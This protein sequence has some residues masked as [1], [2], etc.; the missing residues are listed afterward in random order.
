MRCWS[1]KHA[2]AHVNSGLDGTDV[3][4]R[5]RQES[6]MLQELQHLHISPGWIDLMQL[7]DDLFLVQEQ[8]PGQSL[9]KWAHEHSDASL[10]VSAA[11]EAASRLIDLVEKIHASGYVIRD[12]KPSNVMVLPDGALQLIDVEYVTASGTVCR[13]SGTPNFMAPELVESRGA[14][15]AT[16]PSDCYSLGAT[17]FQLFTALSPSWISRNDAAPLSA[18]EYLA[19]I[20]AT[21]PVLSD[22]SELILGLT[23]TDPTERWTLAQ[24][25]SRLTALTG[26]V[27]SAPVKAAAGSWCTDTRLD[28][29]IDEQTRLL[30]A[31]A[32]PESDRLWETPQDDQDV[33]SLWNGAAGG[34]A[35]LSRAAAD[36]DGTVRETVADAAAWISRRLFP[37]ARLL[38]GLAFGRAGTAWALYDA[39]A[40]LEDP[41][42][43]GRALELAA[44]LPAQ[45]P[46]ADIT[47]GLSGAGM[48][49]LHL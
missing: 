29:L 12:L 2:R 31:S 11:L 37:V 49:H 8:I 3:R 4:D 18:E 24:A 23:K 1:T 47:H 46:I 32:V 10:S 21:H 42:L 13:P 38:P 16:S 20:A 44:G 36:G 41:G 15:P 40:L 28:A 33:C 43:Q 34:L 25:R 35:A 9:E 17:L 7:E 14:L 19:R 39:G 30:Q 5:L 6:Q 22:F 26:G 48:T 45:W 27:S